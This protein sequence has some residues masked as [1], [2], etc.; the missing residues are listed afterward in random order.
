LEGT[1][2]GEEVRKSRS[3]T[4]RWNWSEVGMVESWI[5]VAEKVREES[6]RGDSSVEVMKRREGDSRG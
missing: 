2:S 4:R 6:K 3:R 1:D 5:D